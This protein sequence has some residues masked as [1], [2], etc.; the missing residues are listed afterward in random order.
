MATATTGTPSYRRLAELARS[1]KSLAAR[2]ELYQHRVVEELYDVQNDPD[3]LTNLIEE[4][5][6]HQELTGL[7]SALEAWM[8]K[9]GDHMLE[10][11]RQRN[12]PAAR[13]AYVQQKEQEA[14]ERRAR[15]R[16][17]QRRSSQAR[18]VRQSRLITLDIPKTMTAGQQVTVKLR[19]RLTADLGT[20][21]VYVTL[22]AG[23]Q[24]KRVERKVVTV[25]GRGAAELSFVLPASTR[26]QT[27][28]F[29]AFIG[30]DYASS[31]QH[32]QTAPIQV[33]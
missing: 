19:H 12:D 18:P 33:Q 14:Q 15:K 27:V 9:T 32:L 7:R 8:L 29:A 5:A 13:E 3:C 11:M 20:Q 30:K 24:A 26:G 2:H 21:L 6:L 17:A 1:D 4:P 23:A 22:K 16:K 28:R 25:S 31:L 10:A